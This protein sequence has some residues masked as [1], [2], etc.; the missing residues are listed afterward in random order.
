[1][2]RGGT[3]PGTLVKYEIAPGLTKHILIWRAE[4][5]IM[6][7][8]GNSIFPISQD[9]RN[10]F[11]PLDPDF[12]TP[13]SSEYGFYD[14][15]NFE[16]HWISTG[17]EWVYDVLKK[18]WYEISRGT[19]KELV[20]GFQVKDTTG[21]NYS[22]GAL[23]TGYVERLEY[24]KTFDGI[25]IESKMMTGDIAIGG[26]N[27]ITKVE[28]LKHI[29]IAKSTTNKVQ[30]IHYGDTISTPLAEDQISLATTD[31]THRV[32]M[33][34]RRVNWGDNIFHAFYFSMTNN[35][36]LIG[37]EPIGLGVMYKIIREDIYSPIDK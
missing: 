36:D 22:Y 2:I 21:I 18:K 5:A 3:S 19:G 24:G 20:L 25:D 35:T 6:V 7:F 37:Y 1:L 15:S 23:D 28:L 17:G 4:K 11:D 27:V 9:I 10:L 34:K 12:V 26:W 14:E 16:Y 30:V 13:T 8:D 32:A 29:A 33:R 31:A